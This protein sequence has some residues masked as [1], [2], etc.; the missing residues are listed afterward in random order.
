MATQLNRCPGSGFDQDR[1]LCQVKLFL[2]L[3]QARQR[4]LS[5]ENLWRELRH[6][7]FTVSLFCNQFDHKNEIGVGELGMQQSQQR[8]PGAGRGGGWGD[9]GYRPAELI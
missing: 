7:W 1:V 5:A 6:I 3:S 4:G 2:A 9:P 8:R